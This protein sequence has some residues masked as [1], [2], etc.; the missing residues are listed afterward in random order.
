MQRLHDTS[1]FPTL[2]EKIDKLLEENHQLIIAA[3]ECQNRGRFQDCLKY[4]ER[5]QRNLF[6]LASLADSQ[7]NI[8]TASYQ[9]AQ[10]S[11]QDFTTQKIPVPPGSFEGR[12]Q[13][14]G[15]PANTHTHTSWQQGL[16]DAPEFPR[17]MANYRQSSGVPEAANSAPRY[18]EATNA[19]SSTSQQGLVEP[20]GGQNS[21]SE[22]KREV[23]YWTQE[24][25]QRFVEGLSKYQKDGKPDL[26][27]IAEYLG[28]RTPTQVR[29]HYQKYILKLKKSQESNSG[30]QDS[31]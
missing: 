12:Q 28:T 17:K 24:E 25:H 31:V 11:R 20:S 13:S 2:S 3:L 14:V 10:G 19:I 6:Y 9:S 21:S 26:K 23:R 16:I 27:A 15:Q 5:L 22:E 30:N 18:V 8:M 4:Q 29:S 7:M 1:G